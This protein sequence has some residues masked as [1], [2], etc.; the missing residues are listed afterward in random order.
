MTLPRDP[1]PSPR[2]GA[3]ASEARGAAAPGLRSDAGA[4]REGAAPKRPS[5]SEQISRAR[6]RRARKYR[7][8]FFALAMTGIVAAVVWA[9]LGSQLLVV[10]SVAVTGT[11]LVSASAVLAV[12]GV[13]PGTPMVRVDAAEI[14]SRVEAIRQVQ[15]AQVVKSWPDHIVIEVRERVSVVAVPAPSGGFDLVD[16]YGVVV[17]WSASRPSRFPLFQTAEPATSLRG[18][19]SVSLAA[20][21]L[22]ELPSPMRSSVMSVSVP[23]GQVTLVLDDGETVV[24]G[25]TDRT[26]AKVQVLAILM[27]THAR[28]YDVSAPGVAMTE[29]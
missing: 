23:N 16:S 19:Q 15:S 20:A 21:V 17:R 12:A 13:Q 25:G 22:A 27:R 24:W 9:L 10:R 6:R 14:A 7:A 18:D 29:G 5:L 1:V 11:N 3:P 26:A 8:A 4:T 2:S 28:Y